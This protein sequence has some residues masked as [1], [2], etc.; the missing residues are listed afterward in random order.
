MINKITFPE[1]NRVYTFIYIFK[2]YFLLTKN[3][4]EPKC[5][6]KKLR[7]LKLVFMRRGRWH[8]D[9]WR[10]LF[11]LLRT[12][13]LLGKWQVEN[14]F[15]GK[16]RDETQNWNLDLGWPLMTLKLKNLEFVIYYW[17]FWKKQFAQPMNIL[18][19]FSIV[20]KKRALPKTVI[21]KT[22]Q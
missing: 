20:T 14:L 5:L 2:F 3:F 21:F 1:L 4:L 16:I 7:I 17:L 11:D 19:K 9:Q 12:H 10:L 8:D 22:T 13:P 15:W 6:R 18:W